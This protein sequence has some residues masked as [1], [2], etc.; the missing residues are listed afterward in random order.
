MKGEAEPG[1]PAPDALLA[2]RAGE[3]DEEAFGELLRRHVP[4]A[5]EAARAELGEQAA[6]EGVVV[7]AFVDAWRRLP[8]FRGQ[9]AFPEWLGRIVAARCRRPPAG[10]GDGAGATVEERVAALLRREPRAIGAREADAARR[11]RA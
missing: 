10:S 7:E 3:G 5:L 6:A 2:A 4:G 8:E 11:C 1:V 9:A